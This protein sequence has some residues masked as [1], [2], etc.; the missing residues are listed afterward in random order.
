MI[1]SQCFFNKITRS[2]FDSVAY[3]TLLIWCS[4]PLARFVS[5]LVSETKAVVHKHKV[6]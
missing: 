6:V 4:W 3:N 5:N 2:L 1:S